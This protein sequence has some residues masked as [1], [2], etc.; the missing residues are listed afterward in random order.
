MLW[1]RFSE[2]NRGPFSTRP[3][4]RPAA[5]FVPSTCPNPRNL[6]AS[7]SLTRCPRVPRSFGLDTVDSPYQVDS[8]ADSAGSIP[9]TRST[10]EYCYSRTEFE[11][12]QFLR[13]HVSVHSRATLGH[14]LPPRHSPFSFRRTLSLF[15][16]VLRLSGSPVLPTSPKS[17]L[18]HNYEARRHLA[19]VA[20]SAWNLPSGHQAAH[21]AR[22]GANGGTVR[23]SMYSAIAD[24]G[25]RT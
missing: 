22:R 13:T 6:T 20:K 14:T 4:R 1:S 11:A 9:V 16:H 23:A 15:R 21:P 19:N 12:S 5:T 3:R 17:C 2:S 25:M 10:R 24:S 18:L 7:H 8:Q